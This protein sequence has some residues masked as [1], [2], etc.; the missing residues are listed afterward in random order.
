MTTT[1]IIVA[2]CIA[3]G[4][5]AVA[6]SPLPQ[7]SLI[8]VAWRMVRAVGMRIPGVGALVEHLQER[9]E[10][11]AERLEELDPTAKAKSLRRR[12]KGS[13]DLWFNTAVI[14]FVALLAAGLAFAFSVQP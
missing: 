9:R 5:H 2:V 4:D 7:N 8:G 10:R 11:R 3:L 13:A 1:V 6:L 12:D 14:I